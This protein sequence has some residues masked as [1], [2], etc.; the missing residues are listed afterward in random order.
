MKL[1]DVSLKTLEGTPIAAQ[2]ITDDSLVLVALWSTKCPPC[3]KELNSINKLYKRWKIQTGVPFY[4]VSVDNKQD[5]SKVLAMV[6]KSHWSFSVLLDQDKKL[7][8]ALGVWTIPLT[9]LIKNNT[10]VFRQVGYPN[11]AETKLYQAIKKY[12]GSKKY[13]SL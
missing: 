10:I 6:Q 5:E 7:R 2:S 8:K 13:A 12:T 3:R 11:G 1:S 9:L 4:A